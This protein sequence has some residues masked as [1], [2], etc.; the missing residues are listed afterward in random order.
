LLYLHQVHDDGSTT[1]IDTVPPPPGYPW[2][3]RLL[4]AGIVICVLMLLGFWV[5]LAGFRS[6]LLLF[7]GGFAVAGLG[8]MVAA[9]L[10]AGFERQLKRWPGTGEWHEAARLDGWVPRASAQLAA[11]E[12]LADE[13]DGVAYVRDVGGWTV[14][15]LVTRAG[16]LDRYSVDQSGS[17]QLT[18]S[19]RFI[20][21]A[22]PPRDGG[23][24][25]LRVRTVR[26]QGD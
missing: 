15:A 4:G 17:A 18:E 10:E 2:P 24:P 12:R 3:A 25:W 5:G 11:V 21:A 9:A 14:E 13:H 8:V 16:R 1:V 20:V 7:L 19:K 26:D 23:L 22:L 6:F